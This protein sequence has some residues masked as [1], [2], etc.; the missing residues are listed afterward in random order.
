MGEGARGGSGCRH[1]SYKTARGRGEQGLSEGTDGKVGEEE[2]DW[3]GI[4]VVR[5]A[6][7]DLA[8]RR[9]ERREYLLNELKE[10]VEKEGGF[11]LK[12]QR[13]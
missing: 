3:R 1:T 2:N 12:E 5:W 10:A 6:G 9:Q 13:A 11:S 8:W 4:W 7:L